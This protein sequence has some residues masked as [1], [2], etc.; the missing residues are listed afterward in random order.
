MGKDIGSILK[1]TAESGEIAD[2]D[3]LSRL[4]EEN[5]F[6]DGEL[7]ESE[8]DNVRAAV[9]PDLGKFYKFRKP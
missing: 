3:R 8:L 5:S 4:I 6:E 2:D 7:S 1:M 9:K